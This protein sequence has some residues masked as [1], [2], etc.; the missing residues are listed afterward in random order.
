MCHLQVQSE[1][2]P[3]PF[4]SK[5]TKVGLTV[6]PYF[7]TLLFFSSVPDASWRPTELTPVLE[8]GGLSLPWYEAPKG[9]YAGFSDFAA[10]VGELVSFS[11]YEEGKSAC[12]PFTLP[13]HQ[14][15]LV[16]SMISMMS[17]GEKERSFGSYVGFNSYLIGIRWLLIVL[18]IP[19][20]L[21]AHIARACTSVFGA[22]GTG[23]GA[24]EGAITSRAGGAL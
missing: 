4:S 18:T 23:R 21:Y 16:S 2:G 6:F 15:G 11:T 7:P 20:S 14:S 10:G 1:K 19:F 8:G 24:G 5:L 12:L 22:E 3:S 13:V 9:L 17:P